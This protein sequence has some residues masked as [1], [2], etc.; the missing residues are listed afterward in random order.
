M[1]AV[2]NVIKDNRFF[3]SRLLKKKINL[4][5]ESVGDNAKFLKVEYYY[6]RK[7]INF[8]KIEKVIGN[9]ASKII[10]PE[11]IKADKV[12][13]KRLK[14]LN[15]DEFLKQVLTNTAGR[16]VLNSKKPLKD[17]CVCL[18]DENGDY[19]EAAVR[20]LQIAGVVKVKTNQQ[21]KYSQ[22]SDR[23]LNECGA[24]LIITDN[25]NNFDLLLAPEGIDGNKPLI[26]LSDFSFCYEIKEQFVNVGVGF[27]RLIPEYINKCTFAAAL[28]DY[29]EFSRLKL[30]TAESLVCKGN[31]V[32]VSEIKIN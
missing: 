8:E 19:L 12:A 9:Y 11:F 4:K 10:L 13:F 25:I 18:I 14:V 24:T 30:V 21:L 6:K 5:L 31:V 27:N 28:C 3:L 20:L 26:C 22:L 2:L 16:L 29:P 17:I 7:K 15:C 32:S 1:F 23:L